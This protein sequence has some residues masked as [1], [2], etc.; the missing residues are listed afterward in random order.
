MDIKTITTVDGVNTVD[1]GSA[2]SRFYWF[3]NIGTTT[4]YVSGNSDISAGSDGVA[5]LAAGDSVC[6]ETLGGKVYVLGAGK[7]QIHNTGDK[8]CPFK[9][10][11]AQSGGEAVDAYTKTESDAK[12][13]SKEL[14]GDTTINVGRKAGSAVGEKSTAEGFD[15]IAS[16]Y[17]SHAEGV[18]TTA[19]GNASHAEGGGAIAS[20]SDSHAEGY[21]TIASGY[22]SHAEGL[23]TVASGYYSHAE[24]EDTIANNEAEHASGRYNVS[25]E[26][27]LFSIGDGTADDARHNAFEI[28]KTG[29]KLH[30]RDI[31]LSYTEAETAALRIEIPE[32]V[33]VAQWLSQNAKS[34]MQYFISTKGS[35]TNLPNVSADWMWFSYDGNRYFARAWVGDTH[36]ADFVLD[37]VNSV[38]GWKEISYTP[39]KSTTISASTD[40]NGFFIL[41]SNTENKIPVAFR[42]LSFPDMIFIPMSSTLNWTARCVHSDFSAFSSITIGNVKVFYIEI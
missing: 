33:D 23:S 5:E 2:A 12:Y 17:F 20:D 1:F 31:G 42:P 6:I 21:N 4:V 16:G 35:R 36:T 40:G 32:D 34:G 11:P 7:V 14:Y 39:I 10:A 38:G 37:V 13:A 26:D 25:N 30:D 27:T 41:W 29:G 22:A 28:T 8:F 18:G 24:G 9:P 15:T 19:S 3:R